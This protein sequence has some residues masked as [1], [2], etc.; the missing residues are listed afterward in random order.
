MQRGAKNSISRIRKEWIETDND[1]CL[2]IRRIALHSFRSNNSPLERFAPLKINQS[3]IKI[4]RFFNF[5]I[6]ELSN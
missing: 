1:R 2:S 5:V 6:E 4:P 3:K